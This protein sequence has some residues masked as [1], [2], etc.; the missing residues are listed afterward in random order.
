[1]NLKDSYNYFI[2]FNIFH[3]NVSI[4]FHYFTFYQFLFIT[5]ADRLFLCFKITQCD[6]PLRERAWTP[7]SKDGSLYFHQYQSRPTLQNDKHLYFLKFE[8]KYQFK[9]YKTIYF[10]KADKYTFLMDV[11]FIKKLRL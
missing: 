5:T 7:T 1:M 6:I 4:I 9:M 2:K 3:D 10:L 8:L 11:L